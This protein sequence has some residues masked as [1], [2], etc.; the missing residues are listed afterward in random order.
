MSRDISEFI[1]SNNFD[2]VQVLVNWINACYRSPETVETKYAILFGNSGNGKTFLITLLAD[3]FHLQ[4]FR[5]TPFDIESGTDVYDIIKSVNVS[6]LE[7]KK[8]KLILIDDFTDFKK[9]YQKQLLQINEISRYPVVYTMRGYPYDQEFA[10]GSL[11]GAKGRLLKLEKPLTSEV[12]AYLKK[13]STLPDK[14]LEKIA[15][16]SISFRSAI[17]SAKGADINDTLNPW[18]SQSKVLYSIRDRKLDRMLD[19][20]DVRMLFRAIHEYT[21]NSLKVMTA[22][23][24]FDYRLCAKFER[25]D[26]VS[27]IDPWF[28]NNMEAPIHRMNLRLIYKPKK[29][30]NSKK[31][32]KKK[33][34][35][36]K[37]QTI[38]SKKEPKKQH[39]APSLSKWL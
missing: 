17:L 18:T 34:Q 12:T 9:R 11:K 33:Q 39:N 15:Q 13:H 3:L 16:E 20:Y 19:R 25:V 29:N 21:D 7:G 23:A 24:D 14:E 31:S 4:L 32:Q 6:T 10:S 35:E 38:A 27:G 26:S 28:V 1:G 22:I 2:T 30:N 8:H 36:A 37:T 5:V